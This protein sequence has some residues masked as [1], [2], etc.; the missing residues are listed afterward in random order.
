MEKGSK[1]LPLFF[2]ELWVAD[3]LGFPLR[4]SWID[5]RS[6]VKT[7]EVVKIRLQ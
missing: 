2:M 1:S 3:L 6:E 5:K 4:G 7:D